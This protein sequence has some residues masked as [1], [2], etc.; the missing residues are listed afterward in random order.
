MG[1]S[2]SNERHTERAGNQP[3]AMAEVVEDY[4]T[5]KGKGPEGKSGTYRRDAKRELD[6]FCTFLEEERPRSPTVFEELTVRDLRRYARHL[7]T[8][9]WKESTVQNYYAHISAFCGWAVREGHLE[10]NP[11]LK[12]QAKEP[13]P[14]GDSRKTERQQAWSPEQ[15]TALLEY[16][17]EQA[18]EAIDTVGENRYEAIKMCRDRALVYLLCFSGVR[19]AE[20]LDDVA[21][22]RR[23]RDGL[24]WSDVSLEDNTITVLGKKGDWSDRAVPPSAIPS[25][26]RLRSVLKPPSEDWPVF[27]TLS[28]PTLLESFTDGLVERGYAHE[29]AEEL[30]RE[31]VNDGDL[32]MIEFCVEYDV[33]PPAL[34]T[35]SARRVLQRLTEEAGIEFDD[36]KHGYLAP[37]G[38]RRGAGEVMV[39]EFGYTEA[40]RHLDNSE[41]VVREHYSHIEA[42]ERAQMAERAFQNQRPNQVDDDS[43]Q[44]ADK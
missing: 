36:D 38:A 25:L 13:L 41:E 19:G 32:S 35:H 9:D 33:G 16:V 30:R 39:R 2:G 15:R 34:T 37:H 11:A 31:Q 10:E 7:A 12:S 27:P 4:L 43:D 3:V 5:D 21:D 8:Q 17:D 44:D 24:R 14:D 29:E 20:V 18:R 26:E 28:Y 42:N 6:R 40:A 22:D 23:G 1:P